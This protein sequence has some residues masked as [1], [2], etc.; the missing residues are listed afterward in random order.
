M[1]QQVV[2]TSEQFQALLS[3]MRQ[4]VADE[5]N[6]EPPNLARSGLSGN[7]SSC[8]SRFSGKKDEDVEAFIDAIA[9]YK[10]CVNISE[11]NALKGLPMLLDGYAATWWQG[12]KSSVLSWDAALEGLRYAYGKHKSPPKIFRELFSKEQGEKEP[13]DVFVNKCRALL[14]RLPNTP[15]LHDIHK[16]DMIYS[17]LHGKIR[18]R[19]LRPDVSSFEDLIGKARDI[20]DSL[21]EST[22]RDSQNIVKP[23]AENISKQRPRC[24][25]CRTYG[26]LESECRKLSSTVQNAF[27]SGTQPQNQPNVAQLPD[28]RPTNASIRCYGCNA[29][30]FIKSNCPTCKNSST[31]PPVKASQGAASVEILSTDIDT[32]VRRPLLPI[33]IEGLSGCAYVDTG[34]KCSIAGQRLYEHLVSKNI[35]CTTKNISL[36]LADGKPQ[37]V[38]AQVFHCDVLVKNKV[39]P[40]PFVAIPSHT[41][42]KT[43]LG[44]DFISNKC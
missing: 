8:N 44:V 33:S 25:F 27:S 36:V 7:F 18:E 10:D 43:L 37:D 28:T 30:G 13:T 11:V 1:S 26:H 9:I 32:I 42:G 35:P 21:A 29:P 14:S 4:I 38:T 17:L 34:A 20:E 6:T 5:R 24:T 41:S 12:A 3:G 31:H 23:Q 40:T 39:V 19:L 15:P 22:A 16:I 2:M